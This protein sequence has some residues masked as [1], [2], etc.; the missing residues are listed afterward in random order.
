MN[1]RGGAH[2]NACASGL[3]FLGWCLDLLVLLAF[4]LVLKVL[5]LEVI[6]RPRGRSI[7]VASVALPGARCLKV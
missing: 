1:R 3:A 2:H 7:G 4:F 6:V 5:V